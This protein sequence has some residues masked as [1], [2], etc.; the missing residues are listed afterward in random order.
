MRIAPSSRIVSPLSIGLSMIERAILAYSDGSPSRL[1]NGTCAPSER[2][3][4]SGREASSGVRNRPGAMV[5]TRMPERANSR[6]MGMVMP[7]IPPLE[8][9]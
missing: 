9:A 4:S 7:T 2:C 6:A 1:G 8:A 5:H 3:A